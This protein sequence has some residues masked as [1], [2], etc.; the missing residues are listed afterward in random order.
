MFS[1]EEKDGRVLEASWETV[2]IRTGGLLQ[3][4]YGLRGFG[5][6]VSVLSPFIKKDESVG[7]FGEI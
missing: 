4:S 3:G 2:L 7:D 6:R 5:G 1:D